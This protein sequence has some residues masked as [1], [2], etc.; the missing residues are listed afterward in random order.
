MQDDIDSPI[1]QKATLYH[2]KSSGDKIEQYLENKSFKF[3]WEDPKFLESIPTPK[4]PWWTKELVLSGLRLAQLSSQVFHQVC[5]GEVPQ[6]Y[7]ALMLHFS[8]FVSWNSG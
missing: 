3:I 7:S 2:I 4:K 1:Y 6:I 5:C 8:L